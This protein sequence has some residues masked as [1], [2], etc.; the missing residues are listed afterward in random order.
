MAIRVGDR[1]PEAKF[2]IRTA[3]GLE[4]VST[5]Q[6]FGGKKAVLFAVPGAFTP[7]CHNRHLPSFLE[8]GEALKAKGVEVIA[9]VAVND[10]FVL[11]EWARVNDV[12][13]RVLMLA[14]GNGAFTKAIGMELDASGAGLGV[15]SLR[16]SMLLE[17]GVVKVLNVEESP[18]VMEV[19]GADRLLQSL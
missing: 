4:D 14:D 11:D 18:G 1:L 13:G 9:C 5:S 3:E 6:V 12:Q 19:S 16:Y 2:K 10:A 8:H 15:R 17:D 7:T